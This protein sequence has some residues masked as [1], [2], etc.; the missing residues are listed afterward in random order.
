MER[1][2]QPSTAICPK[3]GCTDLFTRK[4]FPQKIG[5]GIVILA[6]IAFLI[7]AARPTTFY[8][9]AWL[10]VAAVIVD[11]FVYL[12]VPKISTCYRCRND[13]RHQP[14][15]PAVRPFELATAEKYRAGRQ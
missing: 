13:I 10:L 9:G 3:C 14:P 6:A 15:D 4:D 1:S 8:L 2:N 12:F 5:L 11:A 7:L